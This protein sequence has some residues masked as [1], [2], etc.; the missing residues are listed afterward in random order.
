M[1]AEI[2][3]CCTFLVRSQQYLNTANKK[4]SNVVM[5]AYAD[6][7]EKAFSET[8]SEIYDGPIHLETVSLEM[9]LKVLSVVIFKKNTRPFNKKKGLEML[10]EILNNENAVNKMTSKNLKVVLQMILREIVTAFDRV[11]QTKHVQSNYLTMLIEI[12]KTVKKKERSK[13][14]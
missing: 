12:L 7:L 6:Y 11:Q 14:N 9:V 4:E 1:K 10:K 8:S 2:N 5:K 13:K 3:Y